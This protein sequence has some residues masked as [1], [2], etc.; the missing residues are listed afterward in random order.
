MQ[1]ADLVA[2]LRAAVGHCNISECSRL[3]YDLRTVQLDQDDELV[4]RLVAMARNLSE[5][6]SRKAD[7]YRDVI[8]ML[9]DAIPEDRKTAEEREELQRL[10][11]ETSPSYDETGATKGRKRSVMPK[12]GA[13]VEWC[14]IDTLTSAVRHGSV[15]EVVR[16]LCADQELW[17]NPAY[18]YVVGLSRT[19]RMREI[20]WV[21]L[22]AIPVESRTS[23]QTL[24]LEGLHRSGAAPSAEADTSR[25]LLDLP[26]ETYRQAPPEQ[27]RKQR[28]QEAWMTDGR[29]QGLVEHIE[30]VQVELAC[31]SEDEECTR[32]RKMLEELNLE[33]ASLIASKETPSEGRVTFAHPNLPLPPSTPLPS[34]STLLPPP[35]PLLP[36]SHPPTLYSHTLH[37]PTLYPPSATVERPPAPPPALREHVEERTRPSTPIPYESLPRWY[38]SKDVGAHPD[39]LKEYQHVMSQLEIAQEEVK[40]MQAVQNP[41]HVQVMQLAGMRKMVDE[42]SDD[43]AAFLAGMD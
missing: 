12:G 26:V 36:Q 11:A 3:L 42:L 24:E 1:R 23:E 15:D 43:A 16:V 18:E 37:P 13:V 31:C 9:L 8:E 6:I 5:R 10:V 25:Q 35:N 4:R 38:P 41:N 33:A 20:T 27:G 21:L 22:G 40:R 32:L 28:K 19:R 17:K 29:Y 30:L 14:A 7:W 34:S 2:Q 39:A